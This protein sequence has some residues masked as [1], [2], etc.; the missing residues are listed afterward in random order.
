MPGSTTS[1]R[2]SALPAYLAGK[3]PSGFRS[4][5]ELSPILADLN[6]NRGFSAH[7]H[8]IRLGYP[9]KSA[10]ASP[11]LNCDQSIILT[12]PYLSAGLMATGIGFQRR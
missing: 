9:E 7:T 8:G 3:V 4:G 1:G 11:S 10:V 12:E 5:E 6:C 2:C